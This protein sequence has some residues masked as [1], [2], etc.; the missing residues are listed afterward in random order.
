M[1]KG[2][3]MSSPQLTNPLQDKPAYTHEYII[4]P[5]IEVDSILYKCFMHTMETIIEMVATEI[6][7][8]FPGPIPTLH[9]KKKKKIRKA[10]NEGLHSLAVCDAEWLH[11]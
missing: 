8:S 6:T 4:M 7:V 9:V 11:N 1:V 10:R 2:S 3:G 5:P